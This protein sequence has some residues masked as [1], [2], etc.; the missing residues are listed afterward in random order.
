MTP[1]EFLAA[2]AAIHKY[3]SEAERPVEIKNPPVMWKMGA[4]LI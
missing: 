4:R 2:I 3:L 1:E